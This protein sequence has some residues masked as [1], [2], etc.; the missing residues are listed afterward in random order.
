MR[1][2]Q[3]IDA[4][5]NTAADPAT[6]WTPETYLSYTLR[7]AAKQ[8]WSAGYSRA[9]MRAISRRVSAG[10]VIAVRSKGRSTAYMR[11]E[12]AG[13]GSEQMRA[14]LPDLAS[15]LESQPRERPALERT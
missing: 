6:R 14:D 10:T 3:Y 12:D 5:L 9:L 1:E 2:S 8:R 13:P 11:V 15:V 7:G 4:Y